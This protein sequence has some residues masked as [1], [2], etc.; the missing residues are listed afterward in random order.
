MKKQQSVEKGDVEHKEYSDTNMAQ[1]RYTAQGKNMQSKK[2]LYKAIR[3]Y[4]QTSGQSLNQRECS[5]GIELTRLNEQ[6]ST[7]REVMSYMTESNE[8]HIKRIKLDLHYDETYKYQQVTQKEM[9]Q[10]HNSEM[11]DEIKLKERK[12]NELQGGMY[13]EIDDEPQTPLSSLNICKEQW[14]DWTE[15]T[16]PMEEAEVQS[17]EDE[18]R[19]IQT[20][21]PSIKVDEDEEGSLLF[22]RN[23]YGIRISNEEM[24][25]LVELILQDRTIEEIN[26]T[27]EVQALYKSTTEESDGT[28]GQGLCAIL[29]LVGTL[30]PQLNSHRAINSNKGRNEIANVIEEILIPSVQEYNQPNEFEINPRALDHEVHR[31]HTNEYLME[32]ASILRSTSVTHVDQ[33][34]WMYATGVGT[35]VQAMP[36]EVLYWQSIGDG[37]WLSLNLWSCA[38]TEIRQQTIR[39]L[40]TILQ[41]NTGHIAY[42]KSHF[43]NIKDIGVNRYS[44]ILIEVVNAVVLMNEQD[45]YENNRRF[46]NK[47]V[48]QTGEIDIDSIATQKIGEQWFMSISKRRAR[49]L[50]RLLPNQIRDELLRSRTTIQ[51]SKLTSNVNWSLV[52]GDGYCGYQA[53]HAV[54]MHADGKSYSDINKNI[55]TKEQPYKLL[56]FLQ[57][58]ISKLQGLNM[59]GALA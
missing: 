51:I 27:I 6:Q 24:K 16:T 59:K 21:S 8:A 22:R 19:F 4:T 1:L 48:I 10:A 54:A 56:A 17:E 42:Y 18:W 23:D 29:A 46:C 58:Q 14:L 38:A 44:N 12:Q 25:R 57:S 32:I 39:T 2:E 30:N 37:S 20:L 13:M 26:E 49:D 47:G 43:F 41:S 3:Q 55:Q 40:Q 45:V 52:N 9:R 50:S 33:E 31:T 28:E 36:S 35:V 15:D 5:K 53:L 11:R 34:Q 7:T